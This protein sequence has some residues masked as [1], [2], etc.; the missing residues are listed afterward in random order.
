MTDLITLY[1]AKTWGL[2]HVWSL[3]TPPGSWPI[4]LQMWPLRIIIGTVCTWSPAVGSEIKF[5][6]L[7]TIHCILPNGPHRKCEDALHGIVVIVSTIAMEATNSCMRTVHVLRLISCSSIN[8]QCMNHAL[9]SGVLHAC[10]QD[11]LLP[12]GHAIIASALIF[13]H[14]LGKSTYSHDHNSM[15][16]VFWGTL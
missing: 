5:V 7:T 3:E 1:N 12:P 14:S 9:L 10:Y 16:Y 13:F 4:D 2:L 8:C 6:V 15:G 11:G